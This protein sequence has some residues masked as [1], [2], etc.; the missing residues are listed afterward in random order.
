M[1][2]FDALSTG[3]VE[4]ELMEALRSQ[5]ISADRL[6]Q[7]L[8]SF[9]YKIQIQTQSYCNAQCRTCPYPETQATQSMGRM[10]MDL[11]CR[12]ADQLAG[13][14]VERTSLFLMNEPLL[15]K[16]LE[17]MARYLRS[18][19]ARTRITL[20]TNGSLLD[21]ARAQ[22]LAASGV[23]EITISMNGFDRESYESTMQG[24]TYDRLLDNLTEIGGC[25]EGGGLGEL[26][27]RIVA[28]DMGHA[29]QQA[30]DV[31]EQTHLPVY[32]KPL[33]NRAGA[34]DGADLDPRAQPAET[35]GLCQRPFVKAYILHDGR[36][37]LCNCDWARTTVVGNVTEQ[38][39]EEIWN[40]PELMA[41][42]RGLLEGPLP[43][44]CRSCD[45]PFLL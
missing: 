6:E 44:L 35:R 13:R 39:L 41:H 22:S 4:A 20:I 34:I 23:D 15:D 43:D 19:D 25:R 33:T 17:E 28:L 31:Q 11:F 24:L 5:R 16:R 12:I 32:L 3:R 14:G 10:S 18:V 2:R 42:R 8:P 37:L 29:R 40:G 30:R 7:E 45:Y 9:F 1:G 38:S 27:L 26:D 21:L 36:A